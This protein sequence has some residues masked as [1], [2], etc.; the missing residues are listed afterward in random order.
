M[1]GRT[2]TLLDDFKAF[3]LQGNV[4]DLAVAVVIGGAF[5]K[6]IESL[7]GDIITPGLLNPIMKAS[8]AEN[9]GALTFAGMTYGKF[10]VALVN[11]IVISAV[12]FS[13]VRTM[14][15]LKR[16]MKRQEALDGTDTVEEAIDA[17]VE[18]QK[19]LV[20]SLDRLNEHLARR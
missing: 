13:L 18:V 1:A 5:G 17:S 20:A 4:V 16:K 19:K 2:P 11:F 15:A 9:L 12:I 7:I 8:G 3:L 14:E 10:L 6:I